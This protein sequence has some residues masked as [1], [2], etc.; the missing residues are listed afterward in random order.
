[1][2]TGYSARHVGREVD[3]HFLLRLLLFLFLLLTLGEAA[4]LVQPKAVVG[5]K[6]LQK[7]AHRVALGLDGET[8]CDISGQKAGYGF[9]SLYAQIIQQ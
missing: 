3:Q 1:M 9:A 6:A 2:P 7:A 4:F 5:C 8:G